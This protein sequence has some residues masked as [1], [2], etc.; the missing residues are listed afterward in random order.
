MREPEFDR[1]APHRGR[2]LVHER[3]DRKHCAECRNG[4]KFR[5]PQWMRHDGRQCVNERTRKVAPF[6]TS[7]RC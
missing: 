6:L 4:S 3:L 1:I 7:S 2:K 5:G